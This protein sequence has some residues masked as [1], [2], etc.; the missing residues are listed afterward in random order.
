M[1]SQHAHKPQHSDHDERSIGVVTHME[2]P[3]P[4]C[5]VGARPFRHAS[6]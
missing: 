1:A 6:A 5:A 2:R 4:A 3:Q